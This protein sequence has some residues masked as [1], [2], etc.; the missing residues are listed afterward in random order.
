MQLGAGILVP[1]GA[2]ATRQLPVVQPA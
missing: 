2:P 1:S